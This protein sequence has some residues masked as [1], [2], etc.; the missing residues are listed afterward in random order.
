[1]VKCENYK[2]KFYDPP[3]LNVKMIIGLE[4]VNLNGLIF[5]KKNQI[6]KKRN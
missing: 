5:T 4:E 6:K 3:F 1:M 2:L